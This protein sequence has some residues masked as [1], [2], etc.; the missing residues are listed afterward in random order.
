MSPKILFVAGILVAA[1]SPAFADGSIYLEV[2]NPDAPQ[3]GFGQANPYQYGNGGEFT[4]LLTNFENTALAATGAHIPLYS[5]T[6]GGYNVP[7]GY[8]ANT[9][10]TFTKSGASVEG[11]ET[12]CIEDQVDF[13][14]NGTYSYG[15][16]NTLQQGTSASPGTTAGI[17]TLTAGVAWLYEQ[18]SLG[19]LQGYNYTNQAQ[20]DIDA[21]I[22]QSTIWA[23]QEEP[24]DSSVPY[25]ST[26]GYGTSGTYSL[27]QN[28][29]L[30]DLI[31]QFGSFSGAQGT[32]ATVNPY[33]VSVLELYSGSGSNETPAQDQLV[34]WGTPDGGT[35]AIL[36]GM[37][38]L[39][40]A[41]F[42]RRL[43]GAALK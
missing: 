19:Q 21:G 37:S 16:G 23:L 6:P 27:N 18:F 35:T 2:G 13:S 12:F 41:V 4:A 33:G 36:I 14:V 3:G 34:Y 42:N 29:A 25:I 22:L 7:A 43:R 39:G 30:E 38:L 5:N 8:S 10:F 32:V 31:K 17:K 26:A 1:I 28:F 20:R 24:G 40:L 9:T 15:I 11:F